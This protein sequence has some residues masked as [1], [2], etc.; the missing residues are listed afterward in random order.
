MEKEQHLSH[1][2]TKPCIHRMRKAM[3]LRTAKNPYIVPRRRNDNS[4]IFRGSVID[5]D[6]LVWKAYR[7]PYCRKALIELIAHIM[8]GNNDA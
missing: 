7:I 2:R 3:S 6:H 8:Y 4:C 1:G 5:N